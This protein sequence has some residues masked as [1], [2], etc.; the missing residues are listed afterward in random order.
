MIIIIILRE[1]FQVAASDL[2]QE[3]MR[4]L[5]LYFILGLPYRNIL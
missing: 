1:I 5:Q 4:N 3:L 2:F